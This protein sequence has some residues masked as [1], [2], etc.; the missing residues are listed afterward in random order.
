MEQ[1]IRGLLVKVT[2]RAEVRRKFKILK[3]TPMAASATTFLK[4][5]VQTDVATYFFETY[6]RQLQFPYMPCV[7][8]GRDIFLPMEICFVIEVIWL[9]SS[10]NMR[11][12]SNSLSLEWKFDLASCF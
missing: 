6:G 10:N 7:V 3:L 8:T 9:E 5:D 12:F 11:W 1:T 2:H 4:N